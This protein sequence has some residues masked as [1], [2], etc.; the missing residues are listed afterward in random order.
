MYIQE[1][2]DKVRENDRQTDSARERESER[3]RAD[4]I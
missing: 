2:I 4:V 1:E 3:K